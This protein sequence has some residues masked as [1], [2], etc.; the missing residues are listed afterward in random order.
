MDGEC[1]GIWEDLH[2]KILYQLNVHSSGNV[3]SGFHGNKLVVCSLTG[4]TVYSDAG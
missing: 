4:G 2:V 3:Q 1:V